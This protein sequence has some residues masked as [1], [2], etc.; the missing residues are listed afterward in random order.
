MNHCLDQLSELN[1]N[2]SKHIQTFRQ[3][4]G[5]ASQEY[6]ILL[7]KITQAW[8]EGKIQHPTLETYQQYEQRLQD[9]I[10]QANHWSSQGDV[11]AFTSAG[12]I[13]SIT[14]LLLEANPYKSI[15]L[16]WALYNGSISTAKVMRNQLFL[17]GFNTIAHIE[18]Q[19]RSFL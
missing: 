7:P 12:T 17:A 4:I 19:H 2:L 18:K 11:L 14:G 3:Q 8:V 9:F 5:T 1:T 10:A 6:A 16:A 13:A 15:Q